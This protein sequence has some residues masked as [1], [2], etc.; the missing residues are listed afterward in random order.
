MS[1]PWKLKKFVMPAVPKRNGFTT[2]CVTFC[3]GS[4]LSWEIS[5]DGTSETWT[6]VNASL[7]DLTYEINLDGST[8]VSIE[9]KTDVFSFNIASFESTT[10]ELK[11]EAEAVLKF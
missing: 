3:N 5:K 8:G 11:K 1:A 6:F 2:K 9:D 7:S 10:F 4:R